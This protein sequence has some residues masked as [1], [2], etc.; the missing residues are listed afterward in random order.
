MF[1]ME[2]MTGVETESDA[3]EGTQQ[4][5]TSP[6][7]GR[8][9]ILARFTPSKNRPGQVSESSINS[10]HEE[11]IRMGERIGLSKD[12]LASWVSGE[13]ERRA[14][15]R[16]RSQTIELENIVRNNDRELKRLQEDLSNALS[17]KT[18]KE[19]QGV[20]EKRSIFSIKLPEFDEKT[21]DI[22]S[23]LFRFEKHAEVCKWKKE[24][25]CHAL[26]SRLSGKALDV[27]RDLP[28][29]KASSYEALKEALFAQFH[30]TEEGFR[31]RFRKSKPSHT[32]T[33]STY[34][35]RLKRQFNRWV[36]SA[37]VG[38]DFDKLCDLLLKEHVYAVGSKE[39]VAF[40]KQEGCKDMNEITEK[41]ERFRIAYPDV[42]LASK[43]T[44]VGNLSLAGIA[45]FQDA[46]PT[47]HNQLHKQRSFGPR[48]RG[49]GRGNGF[50]QQRTV[51]PGA[52]NQN[53]DHRRKVGQ[54]FHTFSDADR[55]VCR[56]CGQKGHWERGCQ[57]KQQAG[58]CIPLSPC[59]VCG[60]ATNV[61]RNCNHRMD[62]VSSARNES[63]MLTT[64]RGEVDGQDIEILLD[65]GCSTVGIHKNLVRPDQYTG[66]TRQC[67]AF[68]GEIM[69]Y[70]VAKIHL[71]SP[72]FVGEVE[73][74]VLNS[75]VCDVILGQ[76][77][78]CSLTVTGATTNK[79]TDKNTT[80][81][82]TR[83][84]KKKEKTTKPLKVAE[85]PLMVDRQELIKLQRED[86]SL[87]REREKASS[88][89]IIDKPKATISF[90]I[91]DDVLL[92]VY[93][94]KDGLEENKQIVVPRKLR[95]SILKLG[96]D[97][98]MAGHMATASTRKRIM[99]H[100]YWRG[101]GKDISDYCKTCDSCQKVT[102]KGRIKPAPL[103]EMPTI[104]T[105]F[106]R[107]GIDLVGPFPAS[108]RK[109][110]YI[111]TCVDFATRYPEAIP[112]QKIDSETVAEALLSIFAR[113]GFPAEILSDNGTQ[114]TSEMMKE[115]MRLISVSQLHSTIY[116]AQTNGL[117]ERF[118]STLKSMMRKMS[119]EAPRDWDRYLPALLFA[120]REIPQSSTGFSPFE[121]LYG[122]T[123]RGP[124]QLI[125]EVW[126]ENQDEKPL[127]E[128][129]YVLDLKTR[130]AETCK[131]AQ[132]NVKQAAAKYKRHKDKRAEV[133]KFHEGDE[134]L[135]LLP[136]DA[137]KLLLKW[138]GPYMIKKAVGRCD[139]VVSTNKRD[140]LLHVNMLKKYFRKKE[141]KQEVASVGFIIN[142]EDD[143]DEDVEQV[144]IQTMPTTGK[145]DFTDVKYGTELKDV[146]KNE[147]KELLST[148]Q[149]VLTDNPGKTNAIQHEINVTS[150]TPVQ[151]KQYPIPFASLPAIEKE[152]DY[153]LSIG[154]IERST[155]A[156]CS[157]Y[158]PVTKK[159]GGTR[160]CIDFRG[161]NKIT[162]PD[163][164]PIPDFE[165]MLTK[166]E[167][168]KYFT[169]IDL[170]KGYWQLE[171][172]KEHRHLTAFRTSRG[173]F[174]FVRMP[175][176][177]VT[178]PH[179]FARLMKMLQ[180][181]DHNT[182][183]YFDNILIA[184]KDW[185]SHMSAVKEVFT[186]L[187]D[188]GLTARPSKVEAGFTE[189]EFL[190]HT[191]S[192]GEMKPTNEK[193][194][195]IIQ[196]EIPRT[197]KQVRSIIG[198]ISFYR[199][200]IP[201]LSGIISPLVEMTKKNQPAKVKWTSECQEALEKIQDILSSEPVLAIPDIKKP[202]TL[203]T[204][205]SNEGLGAVL[206][207]EGQD[208]QDCFH[209]VAY[210][211]RKLLDREKNYSIV[212]RECLAVVWG[213]DKFARYLY[214]NTF[215]LETDHRSLKYL[216]ES[217]QKN[218]RLMRWALALQ[219]YN[220]HIV[221]IAGTSNVEADALSR[222]AKY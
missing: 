104:E 145:E 137:N 50:F 212:E 179:T 136:T 77:P 75:P 81:A 124:M 201:H 21:T 80:M 112:L 52:H 11:I 163:A 169:Q 218:S 84:Q 123:P 49:R 10:E 153:M 118:H 66:Q 74:C 53:E 35:D 24:D 187:R 44:N 54:T 69:S 197:K 166:L 4:L 8:G 61:I 134:V 83:L 109:H 85:T 60:G 200:Y 103:E 68:G 209:P 219:E 97:S 208:D 98:I 144:K 168:C 7:M 188:F 48:F 99:N 207:Q 56:R 196:L 3:R 55:D 158:V 19:N 164:E 186:K 37:K 213:I 111:L 102:P 86:G 114:F 26:A 220:F 199:R 181:D 1:T 165:E 33:F 167:G 31:S 156:Y 161:V 22:E 96:H 116:H 178:A 87:D 190:G 172:K 150:D 216:T 120:Y 15:R 71:K 140:K 222:C 170:A 180:L 204:D 57:S 23:Y 110:K 106:E 41:A 129:Q 105:P 195:K 107:V 36:E 94:T 174:Q 32:E 119:E 39:L 30:F 64:C 184:T 206:M 203:R 28:A 192:E 93:R 14:S 101:F 131:L 189:L 159:D 65:T 108:D 141:D 198:L 121:L 205:A 62:T 25:W 149:D 139:Y 13:I 191:I 40:L 67:L 2:H 210:A 76:F 17:Q 34:A 42:Q 143:K 132:Q 142:N 113:V 29:D 217:R 133:R 162:V 79:K 185:E 126:M 177:L 43:G 175:F 78:G 9:H 173:L 82:T 138:Q 6:G 115:T 215:C 117:V 45:Q 92:R 146:Q 148:F 193:V 73:A 151:K 5:P 194:T 154:I 135:V 27:F 90:S 130:I 58:S 147:M 95:Q 51:R 183:H 59:Q 16:D 100:F 47:V 20:E 127:S 70:P 18:Q 122:R 155:S 91:E 182:V 176:G 211:S 38:N 152:V 221:P 88:R 157:P 89:E 63:C 12:K 214:G 46:N 171:L 128:Y 202:F 72:Y 160:F 125:K